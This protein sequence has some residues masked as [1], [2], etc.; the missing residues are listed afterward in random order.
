MPHS[1][2]KS[3]EDHQVHH[4]HIP[5]GHAH[6]DQKYQKGMRSPMA[7]QLPMANGLEGPQVD[8]GLSEGDASVG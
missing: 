2:E 5:S 8:S 3:R 7:G 6:L 1:F 4:M